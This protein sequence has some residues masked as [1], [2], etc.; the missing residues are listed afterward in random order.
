MKITTVPTTS[1]VQPDQQKTV[2]LPKTRRNQLF[3]ISE[4][5]FFLLKTLLILPN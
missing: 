2:G 5:D 4:R 3:V 1:Q